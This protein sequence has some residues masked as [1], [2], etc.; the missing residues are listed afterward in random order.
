MRTNAAR[1]AAEMEALLAYLETRPWPDGVNEARAHYDA[2]GTPIAPDIGIE[3]V[4]IEGVNAQVLT[5]PDS[6]ADRALLYL[7]GGGYVFG[8]LKSHA[9][10]VAEVARAARCRVLQLDYR[11][12]PEHPF[13]AAVEDAVTAYQWLL[14]RGLTPERITIAGDSAG[15]GLVLAMLVAC[16]SQGLPLAGAAVC[17][18][19]WVDLEAT[20]ESY[21]T[22]ESVDPLVQRKVVNQVIRLYL[23]GQDPRAPT[24]SPIHADLTGFPP[25]LV[26]VGEREILFSDSEALAKKARAHGVDVTFEEWPGMVHVWHLHYPRLSSGRE[27]IERIGRFVIEKTGARK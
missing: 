1:N 21:R 17:L 10:M 19:P 7:H 25:L 6:D 5:P 20:G 11:R 12:A 8:S 3:Q 18:S 22:R 24:A 26:Q 13:P 23:N 15:G 4:S 27:A 14:R 2:L 16:R 9:G